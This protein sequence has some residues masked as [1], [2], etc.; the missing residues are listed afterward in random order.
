MKDYLRVVW[1]QIKWDG[2]AVVAF[3]LAAVV[4]CGSV[5]TIIRGDAVWA[6]AALLLVAGLFI[7][8]CVHVIR[9]DVR[10]A[11]AGRNQ[12]DGSSQSG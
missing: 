10:R 12:P 2:R 8:L 3:V 1:E 5:V 7:S 4:F 11:R 6:S 9:V